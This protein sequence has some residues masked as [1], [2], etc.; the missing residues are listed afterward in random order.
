MKLSQI[1]KVAAPFLAADK[2]P[3]DLEAAIRAADA[4]MPG[5][6]A[7]SK[8]IM[9]KRAKDRK[10]RD[11]KRAADRKARD[12]E[13]EEK[14]KAEDAKRAADRKARDEKVAQ[15]R[16]A[17]D[18]ALDRDDDPEHTNDAAMDA[19]EKDEEKT[20]RE[21]EDE[22]YSSAGNPST[23][24]GNR[25]GKPAV[26][27]AEVDR[28]IAAAVAETRAASAALA[29]AQREVEPIV[30]RRAFDSA[31][32]AY[33]AALKQLGVDVPSTVNDSALPA[34]LKLAKDRADTSTPSVALDGA[35]VAALDK[36]IPGYSRLK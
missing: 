3:E 31:G 15:D 1:L 9:D 22:D 27:S 26:D 30:G 24:G 13:I 7:S 4:S 11:E 35:G 32:A 2:K 23:P 10:A 25:G 16:A 33:R 5:N 17:R 20:E 18:A 29:E 36:V 19:E 28:R 12:E 6:T 8:E 14:R 34:M 21:A